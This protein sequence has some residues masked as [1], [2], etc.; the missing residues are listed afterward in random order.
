MATLGFVAAVTLTWRTL[1]VRNIFGAFLVALLPNSWA[2]CVK[3]AMPLRLPAGYYHL[4]PWEA[5]GRLYERVGA[6]WYQS[7]M[8]TRLLGL[9]NLD[10]PR[11]FR[12][13]HTPSSGSHSFF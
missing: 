6:R 7:L 13:R 5:D 8:R 9:L 1:S 3:S 12:R 10:I 4:R 11:R 2:F